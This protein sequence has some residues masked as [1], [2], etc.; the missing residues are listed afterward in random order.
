MMGGRILLRWDGPFFEG[1]AVKLQGCTFI[2]SQCLKLA[3][4]LS[5]HPSI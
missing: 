4:P 3:G 5:D 1:Q 2:F